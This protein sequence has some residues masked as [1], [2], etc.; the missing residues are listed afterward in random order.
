MAQGVL[1]FKYEEEKKDF[2]TTALC[3]SLLY[4]DLLQKMRFFRIVRDNLRAKAGKQGWSDLQFLLCLIWLNLCGGECVDDVR[5][6]AG[7]DGLML[8]LRH[9]ELRSCFGRRRQKMKH[10][11]RNGKR[12]PFPSPSAIFRYLLL[13]HNA[14]E[15]KL[16]EPHTAFIPESN[17][18]LLGLVAINK[19]MLEFLQMNNPQHIATIDMDATV[20]ESNKEEALYSYKKFKGYQ[21]LNSW[22]FEQDYAV[23]TEFRDGNVPA[24]FEQKRVFIKTLDCLPEDVDKVY[25]RSDTAGYQHDLLKYCEMGE[26]KR[27]GRVEF[28]IGCDVVEDFKK[29]VYEVEE[30]DWHPVYKELEIRVN[31]KVEVKRLETGQEWAELCYVPQEISRSKKGP[32]YRYLAI[33]EVMYERELPGDEMEALCQQILPFPNVK[34]NNKR[35]KLFGVVTNMDWDGESIIHWH[36]KRCGNS[37]HVHSEMKEEFCGGQLPSGKFG[38]NAAWWLIML[39]S[40]NLNSIM[41]NIVLGKVWKKRR[42]KS[43]RFSI[44]NIAGRVIKKGKE[45]IIRVSKGHPCLDLLIS[46]RKRIASLCSCCVPGG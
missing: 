39:I 26:N 17:E 43:I 28:A 32:D 6:M 20:V 2:C 15:E 12:S 25:L 35:Y 46:S 31:G 22:W 7:D 11:W 9:L 18:Y 45:L 4:L 8:I 42:M 24:G 3:G 14:E 10:Q 13:F 34:L 5:H 40:L 27:F 16:R 23:Y 36:R 37:E 21:P 30:S 1:P 33:R 41:K 29:A 38:V 19:A 44:I